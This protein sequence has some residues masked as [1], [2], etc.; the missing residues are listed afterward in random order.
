MT[1]QRFDLT[2]DA[3]DVGGEGIRH[4]NNSHR[5]IHPLG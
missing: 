2:F 5:R 1:G 3:T 4:V